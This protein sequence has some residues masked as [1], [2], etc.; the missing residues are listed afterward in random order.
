MYIRECIQDRLYIGACTGL[1]GFLGV[2]IYTGVPIH[3]GVSNSV[4]R[5][6][7]AY[8]YVG[9]AITRLQCLYMRFEL[10]VV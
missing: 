3:I 2:C 10:K 4:Y 8:I 7:E 1:Q 5:I 6:I 9:L